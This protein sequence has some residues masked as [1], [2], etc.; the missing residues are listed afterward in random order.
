[1]AVSSN[2]R[3]LLLTGGNFLCFSIENLERA[4]VIMD[5]FSVLCPDPALSAQKC[6]DE[7]QGYVTSSEDQ[8][9]LDGIYHKLTVKW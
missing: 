6:A 8:A 2:C 3:L 4:E 9:W 7:S 1:M 5:T